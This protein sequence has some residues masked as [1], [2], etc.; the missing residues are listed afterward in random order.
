MQ[1][2]CVLAGLQPG[3]NRALIKDSWIKE[4]QSLILEQR[5]SGFGHSFRCS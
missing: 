5:H 4:H 2:R 1:D 3:I